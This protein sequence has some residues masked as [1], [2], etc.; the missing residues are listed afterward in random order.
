M[1]STQDSDN[2]V[3]TGQS[4]EGDNCITNSKYKNN[5]QWYGMV[6]EIRNKMDGLGE[7]PGI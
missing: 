6:V 5:V 4:H 1:R 2:A 7:M 3:D